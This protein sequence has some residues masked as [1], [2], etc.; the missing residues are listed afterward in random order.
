MRSWKLWMVVC[1]TL[2]LAA[3]S[4]EQGEMGDMGDQGE[5][6]PQGLAG[7]QGPQGEMGE[8]G[9]QGDQGEQGP[10]GD[11]GPQGEM[12]AQGAQGEVGPQ[13]SAGLASLLAVDP[14]M[15]GENCATGGQRI[16]SGLDDD[17]DGVLG[18]GEVDST[19][20][21]C[22]GPQGPMGA[23]G[24]QGDQGDQGDQGPAGP[25]G[26]AGA[27]GAP[28][29]QGPQGAQ[30]AQG[31]QG[32]QG[33]QGPAGATGFVTS[34]FAESE[35][36]ATF[37]DAQDVLVDDC[38]LGP[39]TAGRG[40][41]ALVDLDVTASFGQGV[42]FMLVAPTVDSGNGANF[43]SAFFSI[44]GGAN[45][46]AHTAH[47]SQVALTEGTTYTFA[48]AARTQEPGTT[49]LGICHARVMIV[50]ATAP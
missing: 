24:P 20:Y 30:G 42:N 39:Y 18:E 38:Q 3:C 4:G 14:E 26:A 41:I 31:P 12:G 27:P 32:P 19:A 5:Q 28:G 15:P 43:S 40:E 6:G 8:Q 1:L 7:E 13:G 11:Q 21:I 34:L 33:V 16:R 44:S 47:H 17:G 37:A 49:E 50:R 23:Q 29:Q 46:L 22:N 35:W 48:F 36:E 10:Q 9:E 25:A 45:G 2:G